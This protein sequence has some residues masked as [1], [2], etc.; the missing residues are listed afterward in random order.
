MTHR[1]TERG[2]HSPDV[3]H[4][5]SVHGPPRMLLRQGA[6]TMLMAHGDVCTGAIPSGRLVPSLAATSRN[7]MQQ[8]LASPESLADGENSSP[9]SLANLESES[10]AAYQPVREPSDGDPPVAQGVYQPH[11]GNPPGAIRVR[12]SCRAPVKPLGCNSLRWLRPGDL[13]V[14]PEVPQGAPHAAH[15]RLRMP[16][17]PHE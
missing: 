10:N 9:T 5:H 7:C 11:D 1:A 4:P 16:S 15:V 6:E 12:R 8:V 13:E 14:L 2:E 3:T 17:L